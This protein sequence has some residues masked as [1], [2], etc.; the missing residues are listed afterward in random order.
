MDTAKVEERKTCQLHKVNWTKS[1]AWSMDISGQ[2]LT[3]VH[4]FSLQM[5]LSFKFARQ[6]SFLIH[7]AGC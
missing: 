5:T 4:A 1:P 6:I 3:C 2:F 7:V